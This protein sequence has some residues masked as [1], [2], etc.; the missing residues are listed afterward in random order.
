MKFFPQSYFHHSFPR[1]LGPFSLSLFCSL[2]ILAPEPAD[3]IPFLLLLLL[4]ASTAAATTLFTLL[5]LHKHQSEPIWRAGGTAG[6]SKNIYKLISLPLSYFATFL[7]KLMPHE[8]V[9]FVFMADQ[10]FGR[11]YSL[12]AFGFSL[13]VVRT[14]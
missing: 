8:H 10:N 6:H 2:I 12:A 9:E 5:E 4:D 7:A 13:D 11:H 3:T 14:M 1:S